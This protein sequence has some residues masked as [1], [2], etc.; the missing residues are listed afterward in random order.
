M[1]IATSV[2]I[3]L[4]GGLCACGSPEDRE[5]EPGEVE[6]YT[7]KI[8]RDEAAAKAKLVGQTRARE[9]ER[10]EAARARTALP[11]NESN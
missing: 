10:G 11:Q 4:L 5:P 7:A 1:R 3:L 9:Q 2:P 8:D 6:R